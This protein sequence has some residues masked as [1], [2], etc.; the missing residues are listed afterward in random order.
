PIAKAIGVVERADK[1]LGYFHLGKIPTASADP[2]AL[3][4]SAIGLVNL[5]EDKTNP[6][7]MTLSQVLQEAAKQWNQ[8]RVTIAISDET[9]TEVTNFIHE[10]LLGLADGFM[11]SKPA[12]DAALSASVELPLHKHLAV[13]ELL[14]KFADSDAGQ[15]VAAANKRIANILKKAGAVS[16]NI[17]ESLL[18]EDAEKVLF[19]VLSK[20]EN[21]FPDVPSVQLDVLA[22]LREPVDAFFDGVMVMADDEAIKNNRLALLARLRALFLRLADVS[23]LA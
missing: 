12:M 13:A 14:T 11:V 5:L 8:Q 3:R 20:A 9:Q 21:N 16:D 15:A 10:R 22:G 18:V 23:R 1:L 4:R 19:A 2:F 6:I 17:D 7:E